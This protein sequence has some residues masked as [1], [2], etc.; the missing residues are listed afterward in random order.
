[1]SDIIICGK[2]GVPIDG[3]QKLLKSLR[4]IDST[5]MY[6]T[7]ATTKKLEDDTNILIYVNLTFQDTI[8]V[9]LNTE[10]E[11]LSESEKDKRYKL[12]ARETCD[13]RLMHLIADINVPVNKNTHIDEIVHD[14]WEK[15]RNI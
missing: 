14:I 2:T 13:Y 10:N 3:V 4:N 9:I 6:A 1:M 5:I 12:F 11:V 7:E 8:D 15:L